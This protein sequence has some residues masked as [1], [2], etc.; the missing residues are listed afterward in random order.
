MNRSS[1]ECS[2]RRKGRRLKKPRPFLRDG[3]LTAR[4]GDQGAVLFYADSGVP[5]RRA[6]LSR[7]NV[8]PGSISSA[9]R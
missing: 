1:G 2:N 4:G 5:V 7:A 3:L 8:I 9:I 6:R